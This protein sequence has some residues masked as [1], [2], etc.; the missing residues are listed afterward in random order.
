MLLNLHTHLEG[1]VR[2][3][4]ASELAVRAGVPTPVQGWD[5]ALRMRSAADLTVFLGHV[6]AVYPVLG[7]AEAL[8]RVGYEAVEDAAADGQAFVE[9][10]VGPG[11]HA[12]EGLSVADV[13]AAVSSG[14][15][16]A[17]ADTGAMAGV[18]ACMLRHEPDDLI[19]E[20]ATAAARMAGQGVVA[21]DLAGDEL[22]YP[23][24]ARY[25]PSFDM[26]RAA[27]LGTTAHAAE[28][29][30]GSAA[31]EAV[32]RLGVRRIGHG[33][34][35]ADDVDLLAWARAEMICL[36]VCATSNVLTGAADSLAA[37]PVHAMIDAGVAVVLGD[38][39]PVTTGSRLS[40]EAGMLVGAGLSPA[41]IAD[42]RRTAVEV[43]FCSE[44]ERAVLRRQL[45][46]ALG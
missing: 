5:E 14:V 31:R 32:E 8:H 4:T 12:R 9:L 18:V 42:C 45:V 43:A 11:T 28:A 19:A 36:E 38:D 23:G 26:A 7:S 17:A 1:C 40:G 29:A 33:S 46:E 13:L 41:A 20:T 35:V 30:P 27:G 37:H 3:R 10:R 2:P 21:L 25:A 44:S 6:A 24:L 15:R 34:R 22:L 39:D 16:E